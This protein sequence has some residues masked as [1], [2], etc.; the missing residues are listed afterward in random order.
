MQKMSI[1]I[2][3]TVERWRDNNPTSD[4]PSFLLL[5]DQSYFTLKEEIFGDIDF[6]L[7]EELE[8]YQGM[9]V[10]HNNLGYNYIDVAS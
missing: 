5:D 10:F 3:R 9:K 4:H 2:D 1:K 6:A 7:S 8:E